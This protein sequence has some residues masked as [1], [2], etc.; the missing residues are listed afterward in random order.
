LPSPY[1]VWMQNGA[2]QTVNSYSKA[3]GYKDYIS[4]VSVSR[5]RDYIPEDHINF[6]KNELYLAYEIDNYIFTHAD[7]IDVLNVSILKVSC[8]VSILV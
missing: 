6:L 2:I 1:A 3:M 4:T 5:I 7:S 8:L